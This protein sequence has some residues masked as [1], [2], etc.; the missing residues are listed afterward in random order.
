M[1]DVVS[2]FVLP[3]NVQWQSSNLNQVRNVDEQC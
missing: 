2:V 3:E 1:N